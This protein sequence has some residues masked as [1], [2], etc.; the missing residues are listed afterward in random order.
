VCER[1]R[2]ELAAGRIKPGDRLPAERD[3]AAQLG[4][5]R[6]AVREALR[7]LEMSG[8]L[9][10]EQ[11]V[12]G[13]AF[14]REPSADGLARSLHDLLFLAQVPL[15]RFTEVRSALLTLAVRD[16]CVRGEVGD[17]VDLD[18]NIDATKR[19][20]DRGNI[21]ESFRHIGRFYELLGA[22]AHNEILVLLIVSLSTTVRAVLMATELKL[23][24]EFISARRGIV[25]A[26]RARDPN[27]AE[28]RV[29]RHMDALERY[30]TTHPR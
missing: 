25:E 13:G 1:V 7:A 9:T 18:A 24:P 4:V 21:T 14:I 10:L 17:L 22:A 29:R 27:Q 16:A 19:E 28:F 11:G 3:F 12:S 20:Y 2:A 8:I 23:M 6:S 30:V 15:A 26:I 5:S